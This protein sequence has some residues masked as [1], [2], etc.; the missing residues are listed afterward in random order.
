MKYLTLI[1]VLL[2]AASAVARQAPIELAPD[3]NGNVVILPQDESVQ[4]LGA[5]TDDTPDMPLP[6]QL[7]QPDSTDDGVTGFADGSD[8]TPD[9]PLPKQLAAS[10]DDD[11]G[12]L[13]TMRDLPLP[14][15]FDQAPLIMEIVDDGDI[16]EP[17]PGD[18]GGVEIPDEE[19]MLVD[20]AAAD[21]SVLQ[22]ITEDGEIGSRSLR[23]NYGRYLISDA[24]KATWLSDHNTRRTK[25]YADNNLGPADLVWSTGLQAKA[26]SYVQVLLKLDKC[27]IKHNLDDW[28][29]GENLA[30]AWAGAKGYGRKN[31]DAVKAWFEGEEKLGYGKNG[32]YTAVG[33]RATKYVGCASGKKDYGTGECFIEVC[34]YVK[35]GNCNIA[36]DNWMAKM[37]AN[38]SPCGPECPP[39]GCLAAKATEME[40]TDFVPNQAPSPVAAAAVAVPP[41]AAEWLTAH[42]TRRTALYAANNLGPMDLKWSPKTAEAAKKYLDILLAL[43]GCTIKHYLDDWKGGENLAAAWSSS[44]GYG[45]KNADAV[46]AWYEGEEK[47]GFGKNGHYT[48]VGWRATKYFGCANGKKNHGTGECFIEVCRYVKPG[49]CNIDADNWKAK[50]LADDSPCGP[51]CPAEGCF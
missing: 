13:A 35:P 31:T 34:R 29:G 49:N 22:E 16:A 50:M 11:V 1:I 7:T 3:E 42:N 17:A 10:E 33:W 48:A 39:E 47:L 28:K 40:S 43:D 4:Q 14:I 32:H 20:S 23:G 37:L 21:S 18:V 12:N 9:R 24:D 26:E 25:L 36:A 5:S 8:D 51:E 2:S 45:R 27:S 38:D 15:E 44:T 19:Q 6:M 30:A 46:K 41:E